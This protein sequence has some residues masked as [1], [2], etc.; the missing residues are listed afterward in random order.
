MIVEA[1]DEKWWMNASG[2]W[3]SE[4]AETSGLAFPFLPELGATLPL[5]CALSPIAALTTRITAVLFSPRSPPR[6]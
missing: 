4:L 6:M 3:L 1:G 2:S 5:L